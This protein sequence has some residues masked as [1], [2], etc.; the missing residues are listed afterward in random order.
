MK[1]MTTAN[2]ETV[3]DNGLCQR[4]TLEIPDVDPNHSHIRFGRSL[5]NS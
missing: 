4:T 2:I 5:D 1:F 3:V